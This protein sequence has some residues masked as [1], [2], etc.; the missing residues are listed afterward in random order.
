[1]ELSLALLCAAVHLLIV[2]RSR[3]SDTFWCNQKVYYNFTIT[4]QT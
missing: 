4:R 1:M 3:N 2:L